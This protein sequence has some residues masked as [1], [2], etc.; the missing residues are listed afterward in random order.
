MKGFFVAQKKYA[1][2]GLKAVFCNSSKLLQFQNL[3]NSSYKR[4][5]KDG[6]VKSVKL[7][8]GDRFYLK[9]LLTAY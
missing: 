7:P 6:T 9:D 8:G 3:T 1:I 2:G 5:V 4:K